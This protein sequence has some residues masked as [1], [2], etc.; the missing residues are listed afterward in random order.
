MS[1]TQPT[2]YYV[3]YPTSLT[4]ASANAV[5]TY[6]TLRELKALAPQTQIFI[7][8]MTREANPFDALGVKLFA[9]YRN[10]A[11]ITTIQI[12]IVVLH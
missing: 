12:H 1:N 4:L 11:L 8:R 7:P 2:I 6:S 10:W 5:Q 9:S 3:A